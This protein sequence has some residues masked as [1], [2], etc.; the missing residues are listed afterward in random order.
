VND[1]SQFGAN[2]QQH[3][4][5]A[6]TYGPSYNNYGPSQ[7]YQHSWGQTAN[8][9]NDPY[10]PYSQHAFSRLDPNYHPQNNF[11]NTNPNYNY[12]NS[13]A[14]L[15]RTNS[16][17]TYRAGTTTPGIGIGV[18]NGMN[19]GL[20]N[21]R[22]MQPLDQPGWGLFFT[23]TLLFLSLGGNAYLGWIAAEFYTRYRDTVERMRAERRY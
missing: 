16:T 7:D 22:T 13:M 10:G 4:N 18:N 3:Y 19:N 14:S 6:P 23:S 5:N 1:Q 20:N 2:T 9:N 11:T 8:H 12:N 15:P 17:Q 21:N